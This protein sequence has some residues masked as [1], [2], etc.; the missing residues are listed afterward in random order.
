[1]RHGCAHINLESLPVLPAALKQRVS[2]CH[3][4]AALLCHNNKGCGTAALISSV[5]LMESLPALPTAL[6]QRVRQRFVS[7][8]FAITAHTCQSLGPLWYATGSLIIT[9]IN[10]TVLSVY[11]TP[12]CGDRTDLDPMLL[13]CMTTSCTLH[14]IDLYYDTPL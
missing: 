3:C 13:R 10:C 11:T 8:L 1:M 9:H 6:Q 14:C 4:I 5:S 2:L 12:Q 7:F